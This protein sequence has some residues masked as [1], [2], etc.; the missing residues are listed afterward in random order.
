VHLAHQQ[1]LVSRPDP[2]H[3]GRL[4]LAETP[5]T[6]SRYLARQPPGCTIT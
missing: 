3:D 4:K 1:R 5:H 2:V 6:A